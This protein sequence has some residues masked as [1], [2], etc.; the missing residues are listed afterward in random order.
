[1]A[2]I[3]NDI[4]IIIRICDTQ[5]LFKIIVKEFIKHIVMKLEFFGNK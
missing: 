5:L 2:I 4:W 3:T 1:M